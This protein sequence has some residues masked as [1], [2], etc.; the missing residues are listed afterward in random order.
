MADEDDGATVVGEGGAEVASPGT[1]FGPGWARVRGVM[2]NNELARGM[3]GIVGEI[4][5]GGKQAGAR[6][7][8]RVGFPGGE[9]IK[10]ELGVG[11]E[12]PIQ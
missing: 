6:R 2:G 3:E 10:G 1:V 9:V 12:A 4:D 5:G 7:P 11:K 8:G